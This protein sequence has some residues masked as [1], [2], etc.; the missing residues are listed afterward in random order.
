M[1]ERENWK[2][3]YA[4]C[5]VVDNGEIVVEKSVVDARN[6]KEAIEILIESLEQGDYT[7]VRLL[8]IDEGK[9][10]FE[11]FPPEEFIEKAKTADENFCKENYQ[12]WDWAVRQAIAW[13]EN[14]PE[15]ILIELFEDQDEDVRWAVEEN[16][17]WNKKMT[18]AWTGK[19]CPEKFLLNEHKCKIKPCSTC[20][21]G[22]E[23]K[24]K[25]GNTKLHDE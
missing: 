19:E 13:N 6:E 16:P 4:E 21:H 2:S 18:C 24:R 7:F 20:P 23:C 1:Q 22:I 12:H 11:D 14:C 8:K 15:E 5:E 10:R 9:S 17:K 25:M 3:Y